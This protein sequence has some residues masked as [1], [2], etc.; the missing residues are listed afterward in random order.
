MQIHHTLLLA[1]F[2]YLCKLVNW[3]L[4][5]MISGSSKYWNLFFNFKFFCFYKVI[6]AIFGKHPQI[7]VYIRYSMAVL[8]FLVFH[9][10]VQNVIWMWWS[11][12]VLREPNHISNSA[13]FI[14]K[15]FFPLTCF[16]K[17][18][19]SRHTIVWLVT[20]TMFLNDLLQCRQSNYYWP[21]TSRVTDRFHVPLLVLNPIKLM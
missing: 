12:M 10:F 16:I 7:K 9:L 11:F 13:I 1:N 2:V 21:I 19:C 8:S 4:I 20:F 17:W 15:H 5:G 6:I 14:C 3:K 18:H